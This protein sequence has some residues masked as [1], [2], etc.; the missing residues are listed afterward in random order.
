MAPLSR[1]HSVSVYSLKG[2]RLAFQCGAGLLA[3]DARDGRRRDLYG[4]S[5]AARR[6]EGRD[7]QGTQRRVDRGC[8]AAQV[9]DRDE[10]QRAEFRKWGRAPEGLANRSPSLLAAPS[11]Q[12]GTGGL[13][14]SRLDP[15]EGYVW[16]TLNIRSFTRAR[17]L[18]ARTGGYAME[19]DS[20]A[21]EHRGRAA[22]VRAWLRDLQDDDNRRMALSVA[23][24]YETMAKATEEAIAFGPDLRANG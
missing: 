22:S 5:D 8:G 15:P 23:E 2:S 17:S 14:H 4:L 20:R 11:I 12:R 6:R 7:R 24:A 9:R 18:D 16:S 3:Y 13:S 1:E 10:G 21:A 19:R